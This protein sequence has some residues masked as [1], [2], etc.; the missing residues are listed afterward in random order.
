M[1]YKRNRYYDPASGR[2]TQVDPIGLAGG[3][4]A[5]GFGGGDQVNFSDP[6]GL[7]P[8]DAGGDGKSDSFTDCQKGTSGYYANEAARGRGGAMNTAKGVVA[9]CKES[10]VCAA[11]AVAGAAVTGEIVV[12]E[13][14]AALLGETAGAT[15]EITGATKHGLYR[16]MQRGVKPTE[17]LDAVKNG[18]GIRAV[19]KL[20]RTS[21]RYVGEKATVILNEA[22]KIISAWRGGW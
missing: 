7:C 15:G 1:Q 4:N 3:L 14:G 10:T 21:Y 8:K 9:S 19:D 18:E 20:G 17:I 11:G 16:I 6:F 12:S 22:G 13:V 2:F 5:Y